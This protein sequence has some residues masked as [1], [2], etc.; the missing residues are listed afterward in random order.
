MIYVDTS[1]VLA[2]LLSED[3][4]PPERVWEETVVASRLLEYETWTRINAR[5]LTTS[6]GERTRELLGRVAFLELVRPVLERA[7][8]PFP[9]PLRTLDALHV[10]SMHFL[11]SRG[12][13]VQLASYDDRLTEVARA[14]NFQILPL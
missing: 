10:A 5:G 6:H 11:R 7:L 1:V 3:R 14:L 8:E 9:L 13:D 4:S 2:E 12:Q